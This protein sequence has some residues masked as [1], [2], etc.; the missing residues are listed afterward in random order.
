VRLQAIA[1]AVLAASAQAADSPY[2][3]HGYVDMRAVAV[4]SS[5]QSFARLG[6][7]RFMKNTTVCKSAG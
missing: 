7:L 2:E 4:D 3:F 1:L 5:L 6:L